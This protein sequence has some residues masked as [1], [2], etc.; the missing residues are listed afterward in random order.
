MAAGP[1]AGPVQRG[2]PGHLLHSTLFPSRIDMEGKRERAPEEELEQP[3]SRGRHYFAALREAGTLVVVF[4]SIDG[5]FYKSKEEIHC[6]E[7][8]LCIL[9]VP[10]LRYVPVHL[11]Q[12]PT[13]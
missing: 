11:A 10:A 13:P 12:P 6:F 9:F 4:V 7:L 8:V 1:A 3:S 2:A 5:F